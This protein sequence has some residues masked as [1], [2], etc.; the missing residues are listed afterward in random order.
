MDLRK[1]EAAIE[2][3][4][5]EKRPAITKLLNATDQTIHLFGVLSDGGVHADIDHLIEMARIVSDAEKG[6]ALHLMTD[7]RDV[8]PKSALDYLTHLEEHL[9]EN[10]QIATVMGRYYAMDRDNRWERVEQAYRASVEAKGKMANSAKA[11]IEAAY[12]NEL[13]D[14][15]ILPTVI[16]DFTGIK[17]GDAVMWVNFRSDRARQFTA[18]LGDPSFNAFSIDGR[19]KLALLTSMAEYSTKHN[20]YMDTVFPP[21]DIKNGLGEWV[22]KH[23]KTQFRIAETEKYP[24]VTFFFNGGIEEPNEGETRYLAPSP[25]VAT[26]DLQPEMSA[27]EVTENLT[28]AILS[29][30]YDLIVVNYANPDMVGHTGDLSAGIKA[31][32]AVDTGLGEVIDAIDK[33]GSK[34]LLCA[35]HGNCEVMID[36]KTGG[37]HTAHTTNPVPVLLYNHNAPLREDGILADIAP[38]LLEL[39]DIEKPV[40]MTGASLIQK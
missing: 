32:E 23:G 19:P 30:S 13:T 22:A 28:K 25:K 33:T 7:G 37:P 11:A 35:D 36:P 20:G 14:E 31:C 24:H 6:C 27:P 38:T 12:D 26:Y 39:M 16:G 15:F 17:S 10:V 5:F 18:A 40:E 1:I 8:A 3:G 4:A 2:T 21:E 29:K 34:M 9:P